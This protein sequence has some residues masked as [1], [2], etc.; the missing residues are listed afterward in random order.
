MPDCKHPL[1][2]LGLTSL[3]ALL[4]LML[5]AP[6]R[7]AGF[8]TVSVSSRLDCLHSDF[9]LPPAELTVSRSATT[10]TDAV[11]EMKALLSENEE[12]EGADA[13]DESRTSFLSLPSLPKAPDRQFITRHSIPSLYPLRC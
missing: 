6:L 12:E 7:L 3:L 9:T 4:A 13:L 10:V 8:V 11:W 1:S 2:I 5:V